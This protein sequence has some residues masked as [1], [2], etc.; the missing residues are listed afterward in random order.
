MDLGVTVPYRPDKA[1]S[2]PMWPVVD[3]G[4]QVLACTLGE[5]VGTD[6]LG[7]PPVSPCT[8]CTAFDTM[9]ASGGAVAGSLLPP[10]DLDA[11]DPLG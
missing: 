6:T 5:F 8:D 10:L 9:V 2:R 11:A 7:I 4:E 1:A 3:V